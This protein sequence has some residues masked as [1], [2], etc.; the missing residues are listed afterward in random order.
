M[1]YVTPRWTLGM[2][3]KQQV[4]GNWKISMDTKL[5]ISER[6]INNIS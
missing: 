6:R 4:K 5:D 1:T 3:T 2:L